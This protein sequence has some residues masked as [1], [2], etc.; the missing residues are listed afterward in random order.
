MLFF[1]QNETIQHISL[2]VILNIW[3]IIYFALNTEIPININHI[4]ENWATDKGI[5]HRKKTPN[6]RDTNVLVYW[7][8]RND[9]AFNFKPIPSI[10]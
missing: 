5:A 10:L 4:I 7:L 1:N 2:I 3:S 6:W 8:R 9:V